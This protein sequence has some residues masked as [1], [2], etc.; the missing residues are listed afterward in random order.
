MLLHRYSARF[1][2]GKRTTAARWRDG[3]CCLDPRPV[4]SKDC[5]TLDRARCRQSAALKHG[6]L[7]GEDIDGVDTELQISES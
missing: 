2:G 6:K 1:N 5:P 7:V 3:A 4:W